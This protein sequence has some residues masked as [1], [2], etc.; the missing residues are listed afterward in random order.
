MGQI[1]H[2]IEDLCSEAHKLDKEIEALEGD[3]ISGEVK[4]R[5]D[6]LSETMDKIIE[7]SRVLKRMMELQADMDREIMGVTGLTRVKKRH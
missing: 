4:K 3:E 5:A 1:Q 2:R 6:M 7:D